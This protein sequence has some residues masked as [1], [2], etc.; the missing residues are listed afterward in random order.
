MATIE[1][2]PGHRV[3]G[4]AYRL[5]SDPALYDKTMSELEYREKQYDLRVAVD[6]YTKE[7]PHVACVTNALCYIASDNRETNVNYLGPAKLGEIVE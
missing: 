6:V 1:P 3:W 2:A 5:P 4:A 7:S